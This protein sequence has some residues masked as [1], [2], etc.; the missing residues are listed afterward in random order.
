MSV[1]MEDLTLAVPDVTGMSD[2]HCVYLTNQAQLEARGCIFSSPNAPCIAAVGEAHCRLINCCFGADKEDKERS[3]SAGVIVEGSSSLVAERCRFLR[4]R[5]AAAEVRSAVSKAHLKGCEF[6]ECQKQAV[7]L[8]SGGKKL[9]MEGCLIDHCGNMTM[10]NLLLVA[11]GTAQLRRCSF[12]NNK[13]DAVVVQS[14]DHQS[15]PEL[16]MREC[17]LQGNMSGV[18]FEFGEGGIINGGSG[19]LVNNQITD[20]ATFGISIQDVAPHQ[21]VKLIGNIL[22]DNGPN[23]CQG[24]ID[25]FMLQNV[26][27]QVV[28]KNNRGTIRI[29]PFSSYA[30]FLQSDRH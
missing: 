27:D 5:E 22:Q 17:I 25:I 15:A 12:L 10:H 21:Q 14:D 7:K 1:V 29:F 26:L 6:I 11:C 30:E 16:D 20:H 23:L 8:Y 24:E 13:S 4:C 19:I 9:V 3:A 18:T 28:V 2:G